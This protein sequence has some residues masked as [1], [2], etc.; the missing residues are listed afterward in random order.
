MGTGIALW[1]P[2]RCSGGQRNNSTRRL[3]CRSS[4]STQRSL[5]K[6]IGVGS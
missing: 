2:A 6:F 1:T 3:L 4:Q 5:N